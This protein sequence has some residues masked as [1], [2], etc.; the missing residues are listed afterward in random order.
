MTYEVKSMESALGL[1]ESVTVFQLKEREQELCSPVISPERLNFSLLQHT[2]VVILCQEMSMIHGN[3]N[4]GILG[5]SIR[6]SK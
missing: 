4:V 1:S 2:T 5:I 3:S 6:I